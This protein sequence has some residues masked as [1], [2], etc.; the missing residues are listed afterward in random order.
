MPPG[1]FPGS[2]PPKHETT[3]WG[4]QQVGNLQNAGGVCRRRICAVV[5]GTLL[6]I[7]LCATATPALAVELDSN[8]FAVKTVK[9]T[10]GATEL[11]IE[12]EDPAVSAAETFISV[13]DEPVSVVDTALGAAAIIKA[14]SQD[15]R[16]AV[17]ISIDANP[18]LAFT[19]LD[20]EGRQLFSEH[21]RTA[22]TAARPVDTPTAAP[23]PD[24]SPTTDPSVDPAPS[25]APSDQQ[26]GNVQTQSSLGDTG[27]RIVGP[28]L[29]GLAALAAGVIGVAFARKKARA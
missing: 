4:A 25:A 24:P 14:G 2:R 3:G 23:T 26:A 20:A 17:G 10:P 21:H 1:V 9:S 7:G 27:A 16:V 5:T 8:G 12:V 11:W 28:L 19:A 18:D 6:G 13:N 29:A 22:M 15:L